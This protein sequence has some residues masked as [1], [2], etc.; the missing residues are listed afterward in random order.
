MADNSTRTPGA[1]ED[2]RS[3]DR[4]GVKTAVTIL[5]RSDGTDTENLGLTGAKTFSTAA[6]TDS[7]GS[8]ILAANAQRK[9]ALIVN[10]SGGTVYL[11]GSSGVTSANGIPLADGQSLTDTTSTDAWYARAAT[12]VTGDLRICEVA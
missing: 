12:G 4:A 2:I 9:S 8:E 11:G 3:K 6:P 10:N 1:G 7:A 5:D